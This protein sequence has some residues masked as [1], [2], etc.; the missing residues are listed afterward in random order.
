M[1]EAIING[2][3][4]DFNSLKERIM[5]LVTEDIIYDFAQGNKSK[6]LTSEN[7]IEKFIGN[8]LA[9]AYEKT[10]NEMELRW[11]ENLKTLSNEIKS[12]DKKQYDSLKKD[13][14]VKYGFQVG[15]KFADLL[16][17]LL[18]GYVSKDSPHC[19]ACPDAK[20]GVTWESWNNMLNPRRYFKIANMLPF[21]ENDGG[22]VPYTKY[23]EK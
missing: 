13:D 19:P 7:Q 12:F 22:I 18:E 21:T 9:G 11:I 20:E 4:C 6:W 10:L 15:L 16:A 17:P 3:N 5:L 23:K 1:L 14:Q 2:Q 8:V